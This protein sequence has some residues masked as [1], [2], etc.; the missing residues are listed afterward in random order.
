[1]DWFTD[2]R[3]SYPSDQCSV[4][5]LV[6][7]MKPMDL[8][9]RAISPEDNSTGSEALAT[10]HIKYKRQEMVTFTDRLRHEIRQLPGVTKISLK[11]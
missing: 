11:S 4:T 2:L 1:M 5:D 6:K 8:Q 9:I 3:V 7:V 10:F